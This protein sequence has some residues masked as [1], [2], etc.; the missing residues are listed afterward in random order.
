MK[1][2]KAPYEACESRQSGS[3]RYLPYGL[4][5]GEH[6]AKA[7]Y[8]IN[9]ESGNPYGLSQLKPCDVIVMDALGSGGY[10]N[11]LDR[12]LRECDKRLWYRDQFSNHEG[13]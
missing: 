10:G 9:G 1:D 11:T 5:S 13:G 12:E 3:Y 2:I 6:G 8:I 7:Q 4:F